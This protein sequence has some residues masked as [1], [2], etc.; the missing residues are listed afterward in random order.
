[1]YEVPRVA[2]EVISAVLCFIL[3][4]YMIKPYD[5]TREQRYLGLPLGFTFLGAASILL[6]IGIIWSLEELATV[7]LVVKTFSFVFL[8]ITYYFAKTPSKNSRVIWQ[9][10]LSFTIVGLAILCLIL[11]SSPLLNLEVSNS[12]NIFLRVIELFCLSYIC[13]H[14][15]NSHIKAPEPTTIWIPSG[16]I[17]LGISQYSQLIRAIDQSQNY[18]YD[19]AFIG[20]LATRL[21]GLAIF[22]FV[23]Y[24][25][26]HGS[27]QKSGGHR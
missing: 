6:G 1:M 10:T 5:L 16:F 27:D 13:I 26:F 4:R 3:V 25:T 14:T 15:L 17:L 12:L 19:A 2:V 11:I 9:I 8:A 20:G 23:A 7:S 21:I 24:K 18:V 22:L